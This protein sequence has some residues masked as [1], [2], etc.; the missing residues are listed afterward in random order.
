MRVFREPN[1]QAAGVMRWRHEKKRAAAT[2]QSYFFLAIAAALFGQDRALKPIE[3]T[4]EGGLPF[5]DYSK[6]V[7]IGSG[8]SDYMKNGVW[9]DRT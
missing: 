8:M 1:G 4:K 9:P 6:W 7:F 2:P 5:P 3:Y